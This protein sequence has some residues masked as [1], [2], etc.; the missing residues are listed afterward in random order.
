M[1]NEKMRILYLDIAKGL[2]ILFVVWAH[3]KGPYSS[4]MYQFHMPLFFLIS[5]YLY[6][7]DK[8]FRRFLKDKVKA[9]YIPFIL[10][11][12]LAVIIK[13]VLAPGKL[14]NN[15]KVGLQV[16]LLLNKD[17]QFFGATW[18]LGALFMV[19]V[20]YKVLDVY[21]QEC[22]YKHLFLWSCFTALAIIG[23]EMDLPFMLSRTLILGLFYA[24]GH[25]VKI[26]KDD[27]TVNTGPS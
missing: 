27:L 14:I 17:G 11:N 26:H 25:F 15:I 7:S 12:G 4:Y 20:L 5:G 23:F 22:K 2:G 8:P 1:P 9:L 6:H 3:A 21:I 13:T 24:A 19:S 16:L 18:F 10:W